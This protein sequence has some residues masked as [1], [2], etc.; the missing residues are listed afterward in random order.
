MLLLPQPNLESNTFPVS[1]FYRYVLNPH[2]S[3]SLG[4]FRNLPR[5]NIFTVRLDSPEPWN[6]Q[7][8]RAEQD[9]DNL[10]CDDDQCGDDGSS[11]TAATYLLKSILVTGQCFETQKR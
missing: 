6:I 7:A 2:G 9:I 5:K 3:Q 10:R 8:I 1:N 11:L 4:A